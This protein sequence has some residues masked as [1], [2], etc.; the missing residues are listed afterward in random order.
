MLK[1][2]NKSRKLNNVPRRRTRKL[3]GC[4]LKHEVLILNP[5][6]LDDIVKSLD[7][8]LNNEANRVNSNFDVN[9]YPSMVVVEDEGRIHVE[10]FIRSKYAPVEQLYGKTLIIET[11]VVY[12]NSSNNYNFLKRVDGAHL[13][14]S[15]NGD[16]V[17]FETQ[18]IDHVAISFISAIKNLLKYQIKT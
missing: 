1:M 18:P 12:H 17:V 3:C 13:R 6:Y 16:I 15:E 5:S 8:N 4:E 2:F 11:H 10:E 9:A 14:V 7:R